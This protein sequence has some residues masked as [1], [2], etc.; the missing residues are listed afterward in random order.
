MRCGGER[1][2]WLGQPSLGAVMDEVP[3]RDYYQYVKKLL[4]TETVAFSRILLFQT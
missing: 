2:F 1:R 4:A 3:V